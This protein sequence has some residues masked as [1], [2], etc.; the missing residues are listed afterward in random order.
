MDHEHKELDMHA[1]GCAAGHLLMPTNPYI[2][3]GSLIGL[4]EK[5]TRTEYPK[6]QIHSAVR[7]I[8]LFFCVRV[9]SS[10]AC[11]PNGSGD[12]ASDEEWE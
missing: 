3:F 6:P 4:S 5:P 12:S 9:N 1:A 10:C 11:S 8:N 2:C 7:S